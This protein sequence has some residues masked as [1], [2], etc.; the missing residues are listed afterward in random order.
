VLDHRYVLTVLVVY[1]LLMAVSAYLMSGIARLLRERE[2]QL[3][4]ANLQLERLANLR[5]AF[6][7][8]VLH[9]LKSPVAAVATLNQNLASGLGGPLTE[10]QTHWVER[11]HARLRE[12]LGFLRDLQVMAELE[13]ERIEALKTT[14]A[15]GPLL[16][17]LVEEHQDLAQLRRHT[18]RAELTEPVPAVRGVE[19]LLL[20]GVANYLTNAIKYTPEG[21]S[22][23]VR[24]CTVARGDGGAPQ[25]GAEHE[26][27]RIEVA[28]NGPG[29]SPDDQARLFNEFVRLRPAAPAPS[30]GAASPVAAVPSTG[31]GLSIVRRIA[32]LHGGR[33]GV[34]SEVGKGSTFFLEV[35]LV[36]P[37]A[38]SSLSRP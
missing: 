20:E 23:T 38:P 3:R 24:A 1:G 37:A 7:H 28:D 22:I 11:A 6:L 33:A 15:L 8:I 10:Q 35:P 25:N 30:A 5:R 31:L 4:E 21:G 18:L 14:V 17:K 19:R 27:A 16:Q 9:D 34:V 2:R 32:E 26:A 29:L 36:P 13:T 12:L